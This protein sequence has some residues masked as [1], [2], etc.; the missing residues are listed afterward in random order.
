MRKATEE[1]KQAAAERRAKMREMSKAVAA[2]S[3]E[4]RIEISQKYGVVTVEGRQLTPFNTCFIWTQNDRASVV[5]GFR[6]WKAAGRSVRK[7]EHGMGI[8]IPTG[9]GKKADPDSTPADVAH[10]K[11]NPSFILGTVFDI[12]QTEESAPRE[13]DC[14]IN[15]CRQPAAAG[16][17][18]CKFH[19][20]QGEGGV[21]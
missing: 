8:W 20:E 2:L 13:V 6:Q 9:K 15:G 16:H 1:Q 5:G 17:D 4:R 7:G 3:D 14:I 19:I 12:S 18:L 10:E 11:D 21:L